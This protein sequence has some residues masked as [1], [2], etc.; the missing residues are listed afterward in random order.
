MLGLFILLFSIT[1]QA[2]DGDKEKAIAVVSDQL[3]KKFYESEFYNSIKEKGKITFTQQEEQKA[4]KAKVSEGETNSS[5]THKKVVQET[6]SQTKYSLD[7]F[8]QKAQ[9]KQDHYGLTTNL[10]LNSFKRF[11]ASIEQNSDSIGLLTKV[12]LLGEGDSWKASFEKKITDEISSK[13]STS[14]NEVNSGV[15]FNLGF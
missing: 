9:I 1:L 10:K 11:T 3:L 5:S 13:L 4:T 8:K 14:E 12:E 2:A 6:H 15:Y 7:L